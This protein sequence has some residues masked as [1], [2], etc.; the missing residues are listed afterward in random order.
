MKNVFCTLLLVGICFIQ[1]QAQ[2]TGYPED[3]I[4]EEQLDFIY[5][6][7]KNYGLYKTV[8]R[9]YLD[10]FQNNLKTEMGVLRNKIKDL[11]AK[12][13]TLET[14][15]SSV[16]SQN[17]TLET[18][19]KESQQNVDTIT[20]MGAQYNKGSY[21]YLM[22]TIIGLLLAAT[23]LVG[24]Q[25]M[26]KVTKIK[27][28]RAEFEKLEADLNLLREQKLEKEIVLKRKL[29]TALNQLEELKMN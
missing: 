19:L 7:G 24:V 1:G 5:D 13:A 23:V 25:Y 18:Q 29:Q 10:Q 4:L 11:E 12:T 21:V 27:Q 28:E 20:V 26:S 17:A 3:S 6:A 16:S 22:F 2:S 8:R 15:L 9:E 14:S